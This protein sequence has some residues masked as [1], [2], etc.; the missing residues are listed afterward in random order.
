MLFRRSLIVAFTTLFSIN[1]YAA[2]IKV[3]RYATTPEAGWN[4]N[5]YW[6]ESDDGIVLIDALL[7]ID[8]AKL[9]AAMLKSTRK[10]V[11]GMVVTHYHHDH[12]GGIN[13]L[14]NELGPFPIYS[15]RGTT[16]THVESNEFSYGFTTS[17]YGDRFDATLVK[18]DHPIDGKQEIEIAGIKLIIED[19]GPGE[20]MAATIIYQPDLKILFTGDATVHHTITY[21][22]ES[23]SMEML[24][25]LRHLKT[26][27]QH[28]SLVY[29]GHGDPAPI[30][31][32]DR[33]IAYI[34]Y[35]Q[36]LANE[37]ISK[38]NFRD[39]ETGN[40]R[41]EITNHYS[42]MIMEKFPALTAYGFGQLNMTRQNLHGII[43]EFE[44]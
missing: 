23:R 6:L 18:P 32:I 35:S 28:A 21:T 2:D 8:D 24:R 33:Q 20:S 16:D 42:E 26:T 5:A 34:E 11:K 4:A 14:L 43:K 44:K 36:N 29:S 10:P 17:T 15:G 38:G 30:E 12:T 13:T 37:I 1:T 31:H 25:Q 27:Y 40:F 19:I 3:G 9:W 41:Q 22:T 39:P 7:L